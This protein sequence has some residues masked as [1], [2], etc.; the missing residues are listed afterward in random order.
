M[1][2][3]KKAMNCWAP[4]IYYHA[5][6][7]EFIIFWSTTIPGRFPETDGTGDRDHNHR[8]YYVTSKDM[9]QFSE[10]RLFYDPGFNSIDGTLLKHG[11]GFYMFLKDETKRPV[12]HKNIKV[13]TAPSPSGPWS[14]ASE[15]I[16]QKEWAEGPT[17]GRV[18]DRWILYFDRYMINSYGAVASKDLVHWED[19]SEELR[20]PEG[21]RHGTILRIS[22]EQ[23]SLL[24]DQP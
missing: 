18:G 4:E 22:S 12:A 17:I 21:T 19:I 2:H 8:M 24:K 11:E 5:P 7:K 1:D 3:E 20:F 23:L 15:P 14:P 6:E 9:K 16:Y 13:A 10:T